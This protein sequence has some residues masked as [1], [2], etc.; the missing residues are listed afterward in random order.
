MKILIIGAHPD[1]YELG[2]AGTIARHVK[3]GDEVYAIIVTGGEKIGSAKERKKEA[4]ESARFLGVKSLFFLRLV[5][6]MVSE[7]S[8]TIDLLEK[9]CLQIKPDRV[10]THSVT[11]SHQD[12]RNTAKATISACRNVKQ[13]LFYESPSTE[14]NFSPNFFVDISEFLDQKIF[15]LEL[16]KSLNK[17]GQRRYLEIEAIK[18][19]AFFRGYQARLR[20]AEAFEVFKFV[21]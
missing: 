18:G 13:L 20:Y 6:T 21:E 7:G 15:S 16:Y 12:H 9:Y 3:N 10:Y 5:D 17:S 8:E 1:D 2:M 14:V 11:D 19:G 4:E